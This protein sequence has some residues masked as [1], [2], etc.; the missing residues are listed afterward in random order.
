[1]TK[2]QRDITRKIR[3]L[4]HSQEAKNISKTCPVI[5]GCPSNVSMIGKRHIRNMEIV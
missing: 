3:V 1:M 2:A 5:L 4:Q